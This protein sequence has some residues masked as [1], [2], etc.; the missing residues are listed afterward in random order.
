MLHEV[1]TLSQV[2]IF[3]TQ[4]FPVCFTY[5]LNLPNIHYTM[6][7]KSYSDCFQSITFLKVQSLTVEPLAV[8]RLQKYPKQNESLMPSKAM[9]KERHVNI[10]LNILLLFCN[11]RSLKKIFLRHK[12]Y[13]IEILY[14]SV[15]YDACLVQPQKNCFL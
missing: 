2:L 1:K 11:N 14:R 13:K 8:S 9:M 6:F 3:F 10:L 7:S 12:T 4:P 15:I 5:F